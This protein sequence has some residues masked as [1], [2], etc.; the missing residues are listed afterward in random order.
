[1]QC[2]MAVLDQTAI[3]KS[4]SRVLLGDV[5]EL[6]SKPKLARVH[7]GEPFGRSPVVIHIPLELII[8]L[9]RTHNNIQLAQT[10]PSVQDLSQ[11]SSKNNRP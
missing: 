4:L 3:M 9:H 10:Q 8:Q 11:N 5:L 2:A 1:M 7:L 6:P